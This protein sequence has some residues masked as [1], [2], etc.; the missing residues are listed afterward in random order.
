MEP[1]PPPQS[2]GA[3]YGPGYGIG[4]GKLITAITSDHHTAAIYYC[5]LHKSVAP[6]VLPLDMLPERDEIG[7]GAAF[8]CHFDRLEEGSTD[9]MG[10]TSF[11]TRVPDAT[12][13]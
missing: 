11:E 12:D 5:P 9:R 13:C 1:P 2:P 4:P 7:R 3:V 10:G 8:N 6:D